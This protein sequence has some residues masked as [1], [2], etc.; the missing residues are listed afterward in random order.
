MTGSGARVTVFG[1]MV[2]APLVGI[3]AGCAPAP[4]NPERAAG[5]QSALLPAPAATLTID[6]KADALGNPLPRGTVL[7]EQYADWGIH[8]ENG[9][10]LGDRVVDFPDYTSASPDNLIC[11]YQASLHMADVVSWTDGRCSGGPTSDSIPLVMKLDFP[12][13][14]VSI[15]GKGLAVNAIL[16]PATVTAVGL[17]SAGKQ[18]T[19]AASRTIVSNVQ[20]GAGTFQFVSEGTGTA[21]IPPIGIVANP[22]LAVQNADLRQVSFTSQNLGALDDVKIIAC[23]PVVA[24]CEDRVVCVAA[25]QPCPSPQSV[26][27]DDGSYDWTGQP[28]TLTQ[29]VDPASPPTNT[30]T[31]VKLTVTDGGDTE[32]CTAKVDC[33]SPPTLTCGGGGGGAGGSGAGGSGAGGGGAGGSG[34]GGSGTGAAGSGGG[35]GGGTGNAG[36]SANPGGGTSGMA[37]GSGGASTAGGAGGGGPGGG[38]GGLLGGTGGA[39]ANGGGTAGP[40]CGGAGSD[41]HGGAG[42]SG[43]VGGT[44][45]AGPGGAAGDAGGAGG[46]AAADAGTGRDAGPDLGGDASDAGKGGPGAGGGCDVAPSESGGAFSLMALGCLLALY[47]RR[48]RRRAPT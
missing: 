16:Q 39:T 27:I 33:A 47:R 7:G 17:D 29:A 43:D 10:V 1:L 18:T 34:T 26:S 31:Q 36:G 48:P 28:L 45:T 19:V 21:A 3:A 22:G 30:T 38:S 11:T 14:F 20:V 12:A 13:C 5:V 44:I 15:A 6:F 8:F 41:G 2:V 35:G 42:A 40:C 46:P 9:F 24:R 25:G 37:G 4:G 23:N 32:T